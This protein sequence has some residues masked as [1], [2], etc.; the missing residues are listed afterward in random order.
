MASGFGIG[1][2]LGA[3]AA[4]LAPPVAVAL[5]GIGALGGAIAGRVIAS[6]VSADDWDPTGGQRSYVGANSPDD[7]LATA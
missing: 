3:L 1:A 6:R 4:A 7:D 5:V 2:G